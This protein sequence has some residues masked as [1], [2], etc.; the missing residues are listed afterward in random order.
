MNPSDNTVH[1]HYILSKSMSC[2]RNHAAI[3]G[4]PRDDTKSNYNLEIQY[5]RASLRPVTSASVRG[6]SQLHRRRK[7]T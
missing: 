1:E 4:M 6:Q 3:N 7:Q 5:S 2:G